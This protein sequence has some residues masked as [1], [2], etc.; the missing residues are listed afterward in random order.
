MS[1]FSGQK[2]LEKLIF[3]ANMTEEMELKIGS[4]FYNLG[5]NCLPWWECIRNVIIE[6]PMEYR[7]KLVYKVSNYDF[8]YVKLQL[9]QYSK[10]Q[11]LFWHRWY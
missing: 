3:H 7:S 6:I 9:I 8:I 2:T 11:F 10:P 5:D 1:Y 4:Y